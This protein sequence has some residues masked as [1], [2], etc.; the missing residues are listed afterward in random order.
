MISLVAPNEGVI[1]VANNVTLY[2]RSNCP[3]CR[4]VK[5]YLDEK[6]V[7]YRERDV[8]RDQAALADLRRIN[9]PGLP[10][11]V[12]DGEAVFGFDRVRLDDLLKAKCV[13]LGQPV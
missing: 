5:H 1:A 12:I 6:H 3:H 2:T 7:P 10:M 13:P 11:T 4:L 8:V 9:A